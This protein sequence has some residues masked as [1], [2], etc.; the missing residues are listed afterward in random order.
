[1]EHSK[2]IRAVREGSLGHLLFKNFGNR[3]NSSWAGA[4]QLCLAFR[5]VN[6][7]VAGGGGPGGRPLHF[8]FAP[9]TVPIWCAI[10]HQVFQRALGDSTSVQV[11]HMHPCF[12]GQHGLPNWLRRKALDAQGPR[13][14]V[15]IKYMHVGHGLPEACFFLVGLPFELE[16]GHVVVKQPNVVEVSFQAHVVHKLLQLKPARVGMFTRLP[17][18]RDRANDAMLCSFRPFAD[19]SPCDKGGQL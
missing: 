13:G 1:M 6:A 15:R 8:S 16:Q 9:T 11:V 5:R 14:F 4:I 18:V 3:W 7:L 19:F 10:G 17:T 12:T 2:R